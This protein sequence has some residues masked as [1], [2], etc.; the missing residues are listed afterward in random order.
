MALAVLGI[1]AVD[2]LAIRGM[3]ATTVTVSEA[4]RR[5]QQ[6]PG[7]VT[8]VGGGLPTTMR[9]TTSVPTTAARTA[10]TR[11]TPPSTSATTVAAA[12]ARSGP[13]V[14][15]PA[16]PA[17]PATA[18]HRPP[19]GVYRYATDGFESVSI[20]GA[21]RR[22]PPDTTRTVRH[23]AGCAWTF[24]VILLEEHQEEHTACSGPGVLDLT[25]SSNDVRWFGLATTTTL[26]CDP[27]IRHVDIAAGVGSRNAFLCR[28]GAE[29]T[30]SGTSSVVGEETVNVGGESRWAWRLS[31]MGS[32]E[33]KT[34][35]TVTVTELIDKETWI[36]LFEQRRNE[37]R[38]QSLLGD[39]AY[40]QE[41][42]L[43]LLSLTPAG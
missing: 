17:T 13:S 8:T 23:G 42:T 6:A 21:R 24:R 30:F 3:D 36:T 19:P 10:R 11:P 9:P 14:A 5:F 32:F 28:E 43:R 4:M 2:L 15:S 31:V 38:Q 27:A 1:L 26:A 29:S 34:R 35:G 22:Y 41:V 37:L 16:G 40:R 33:G 18:V 25:A 39:I 7:A 20:L 12:T